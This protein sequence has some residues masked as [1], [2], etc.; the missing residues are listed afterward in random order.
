MTESRK[1]LAL[2]F[3]VLAQFMIV[4]DIS[5]VNVAAPSIEKALGLQESDL[6]WIVT[7]YTLAFGGFLL[8]GGRTADIF[9][10][11]R[12]FLSGVVGFTTMS[13]L[14]GI[15][16]SAAL[17]VPLRALQGLSAA[18]MSPSALSIILTIFRD[19]R[20]RTRALS[21]WGAV[22]ASGATA[23]ILLGGILTEYLNWRWNFF[24]NVPVGILVIIA[25]LVLVPAHET[26]ERTKTLDLPGAVLIT[27]A[28]IL[29]VLAISNG[30]AWGWAS[31][32]F[33]GT[34]VVS[35]LLL[36][37]FVWNESRAPHPL[38]PLSIF[39]IGN[40]AGA[41]LVMFPVAACIFSMFFFLSLYF[42][43]VEH[44][45][46]L[47]SGLAFLPTTAT[48]A[49]SAI[50]APRIIRQI[51]YKIILVVAPLLLCAGLL[52]IAQIQVD[53]AYLDILPGLL[54]VAVGMGFSFVSLVVAAT[55]GVPGQESGL[56]SGLITTA[57]QIGGSL[58][59][60]VLSSIASAHTLALSAAGQGSSSVVLVAGF[61]TAFYI[62]ACFA[63][64][65]SFA[66]FFLIQQQ[67]AGHTAAGAHI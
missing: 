33:V 31:L 4:L 64:F 5:I 20:S 32:A 1:W 6:Q 49:M 47:M 37:A 50:L 58:G 34:I 54:L 18:F 57:Q 61:Q 26:Q 13:L 41:D 22:G 65:A 36:A 21:I 10:R 39:R 3:L 46:P 38:M 59:L 52:T 63:A 44:Y 27:S 51:G 30:S 66:A 35:A 15:T 62:S 16:Q 29:F 11:R 24:I 40:V 67:R 12:V 2:T 53:S 9:G 23:G 25:S 55:S 28:L 17:L 43:N 56:A 19:A 8:L 45:Q 14:V 48:I 60:A 7:A 42:Q